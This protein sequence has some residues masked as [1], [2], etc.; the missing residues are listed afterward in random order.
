MLFSNCQENIHAKRRA[1]ELCKV[2]ISRKYHQGKRQKT[3]NI[4]YPHTTRVIML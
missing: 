1:G 3:K 4:I 2:Y